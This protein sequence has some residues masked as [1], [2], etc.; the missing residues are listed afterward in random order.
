MSARLGPALGAAGLTGAAVS[1]AGSTASVNDL[2]MTTRKPGPR[3]GMPGG[4][5]CGDLTAARHR[6]RHCAVHPAVSR[7]QAVAVASRMPNDLQ[8]RSINAPFRQVR[9]RPSK[10]LNWREERVNR[11]I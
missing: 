2:A 3:N 1:S 11:L 7:R 6:A 9:L 4:G 5:G 10:T 8:N